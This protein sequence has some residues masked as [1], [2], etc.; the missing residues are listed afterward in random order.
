M[1]V[2]TIIGFSNQL[3]QMG[4]VDVV[5]IVMAIINGYSQFQQSSRPTKYNRVK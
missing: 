1:I 4:Q 3:G 2:K 5:M